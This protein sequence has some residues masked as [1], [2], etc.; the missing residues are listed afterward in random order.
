MKAIQSPAQGVQVDFDDGYCPTWENIIQS[1]YNINLVINTD[2]NNN[3]V[4]VI[5]TT[6]TTN[7]FL[8]NNQPNSKPSF[9]T[10]NKPNSK[11][12]FFTNNKP[13]NNKAKSHIFNKEPMMMDSTYNNFNNKSNQNTTKITP[14]ILMIRPRA[15]N[16]RERHLMI[17]GREILGA[18][19]D[20]GMH[21]YHNAHKLIEQKLPITFYLSKI[22]HYL[23]ARVWNDIF[24]WCEKRLGLAIGSIRACVLIENVCATFQ[25]HEILYELRSHAIGLNC[26]MW[27]Y[28]ASFISKFRHDYRFVLPERSKYVTMTKKFMSNYREL[29]IYTCHKHKAI[30]TGGMTPLAKFSANNKQHDL[31]QIIQS[32]SYEFS[33]GADGCLVYHLDLIKPLLIEWNNICP[34]A[35]NQMFKFKALN[36]DISDYYN[37][38][39]LLTLPTG[40]ISL[41]GLIKNICVGILFIES[42]FNG[43]GTYILD[44]KIEDS[45]TAEISRSQVW[46]WLR[47]QATLDTGEVIDRMLVRQVIYFYTKQEIKRRHDNNIQYNQDKFRSAIRLFEQIVN[48]RN[49]IPFITSFLYNQDIFWQNCDTNWL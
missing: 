45:A 32:K 48:Q 34:N 31:N 42:W 15:F 2:N 29:V 43:H 49:F 36:M 6:T 1:Y 27:D 35:T 9:F 28:A 3:R 8:S 26:G 44:G 11:P 17:N 16:M 20:F 21:V 10:S 19:L 47:H 14:T 39:I 41:N 7:R 13:N 12:S 18:L 22:E 25:T 37:Q 46:Q 33:I 24:L 40:T 5:P 38:N 4:G 30:A 23:E